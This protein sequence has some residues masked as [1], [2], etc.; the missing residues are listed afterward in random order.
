MQ[1]IGEMCSYLP[2]KG[3]FFHFSA[4]YVDPALGFASSLIYTYTALMFV[5]IEA[6]PVQD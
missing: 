1:A 4:R 2:I 6:R 3:S 5:C